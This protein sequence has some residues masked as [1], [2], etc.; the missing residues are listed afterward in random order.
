MKPNCHDCRWRGDVPGDAHSCCD[1][2][3]LNDGNGAMRWVALQ[4]FYL[5]GR[6]EPLE[7]TANPTGIRRGWF[8]W[9]INFDPRWLES[10]RGFTAKETKP[11]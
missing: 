2:P 4:T 6:Y 8:M 10:C 9:P 1:H 5:T 7:L 11:V 3:S